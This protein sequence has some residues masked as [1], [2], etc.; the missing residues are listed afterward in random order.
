MWA[1]EVV[2]A[3]SCLTVLHVAM[4]IHVFIR[5]YYPIVYECA[6]CVNRK[7]FIVIKKNLQSISVH[8]QKCFTH[9]SFAFP[10]FLFVDFLNT[11]E[12]FIDKCL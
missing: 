12:M 1:K 10:T 9:L 6:T 4:R 7:N 2:M 5:E 3:T 11:W 8:V